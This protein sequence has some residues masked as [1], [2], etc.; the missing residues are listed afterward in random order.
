MKSELRYILD[1][2][3]IYG[4]DFPGETFRVLT[5]KEIKQLGDYRPC[6]LVLEALDNMV[7]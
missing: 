2:K 7:A 1:P 4:E 6:R 3:D 5:E